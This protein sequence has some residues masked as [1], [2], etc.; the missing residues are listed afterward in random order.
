MGSGLGFV[1]NELAHK[2]LFWAWYW[3][4]IYCP[5][6]INWAQIEF[7]LRSTNCIFQAAFAVKLQLCSMQI[8]LTYYATSR[9]MKASMRSLLQTNLVREY[10]RGAWKS[11]QIHTVGLFIFEKREDKLLRSVFKN[12]NMIIMVINW[13]L[14]CKS[15]ELLCSEAWVHY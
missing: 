5:L 7:W 3:Y 10:K 8:A 6:T 11:M 13:Y 1:E 14:I 4:W 12:C 2:K 9:R 15:M